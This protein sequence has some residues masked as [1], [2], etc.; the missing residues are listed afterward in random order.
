MHQYVMGKPGKQAQR[1]PS[2]TEEV[3]ANRHHQ[4][5]QFLLPNLVVHSWTSS[6]T[7][8]GLLGGSPAIPNWDWL[9]IPSDCAQEYRELYR[10]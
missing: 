4:I 8:V 7:C 1:K 5:R 9:L 10:R 6:F 3:I 2:V